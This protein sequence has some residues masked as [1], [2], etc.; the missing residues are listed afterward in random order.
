MIPSISRRAP[1]PGAVQESL[2]NL[3]ALASVEGAKCSA[4][5]RDILRNTTD[6]LKAV[7]A[8]WEEYKIHAA[9]DS[10]PAEEKKAN[11]ALDDCMARLE[12]AKVALT[13]AAATF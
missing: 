1:W 13:Q 3:D 12:K 5:Q 7:L 2:A 8:E 10:D 4:S 6:H 11:L 9:H